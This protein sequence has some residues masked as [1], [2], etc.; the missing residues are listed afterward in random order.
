MRLSELLQYQRKVCKKVAHKNVLPFLLQL[1]HVTFDPA[2]PYFP[3]SQEKDG[4]SVPPCT[5]GSNQADA[6]ATIRGS[7]SRHLPRPS[8]ARGIPATFSSNE[9]R[10]V[11]SVQQYADPSEE[12]HTR[13]SGHFAFFCT[14]TFRP[15]GDNGLR[16][17]R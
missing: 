12:S 17:G 13:I 5:Q 14:H 1:L 8:I 15:C 11:A 4:P 16:N 6:S 10:H 2:L 7:D 3:E 9:D